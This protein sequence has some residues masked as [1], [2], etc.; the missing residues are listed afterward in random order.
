MPNVTYN[1]PPDRAWY[2]PL[3][4]LDN[5]WSQA[6]VN[7]GLGVGTPKLKAEDS[8]LNQVI[9]PVASAVAS[10]L[11]GMSGARAVRGLVG[12]KPREAL[13]VL[14]ASDELGFTKADQNTSG[15]EIGQ[16]IGLISPDD[17]LGTV[18]GMALDAV[19]NPKAI[20]GMGRVGVS[21]ARTLAKPPSPRVGIAAQTPDPSALGLGLGDAIIKASE[22]GAKTP[23]L[24]FTGD[25]RLGFSQ[26]SR[27]AR[28]I[29]KDVV[30]KAEDA[31]DSGT[32]PP[33]VDGLDMRLG[34]FRRQFPVYKERPGSTYSDPNFNKVGKLA[35]PSDSRY[36]VDKIDEY[37]QPGAGVLGYYDANSPHATIYQK[38][39]TREYPIHNRAIKGHVGQTIPYDDTVRH[40]VTHGLMDRA[41]RTG[42]IGELPAVMR[43]A[44]T[45]QQS[46][47]PFVRGI[48]QFLNEATA[49]SLGARDPATQ[50]R[51]AAGF[52]FNPGFAGRSLY[53]RDVGNI[54]LPAQWVINQLPYTV[55]PSTYAPAGGTALLAAIRNGGEVPAN[56]EF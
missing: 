47:S 30:T 16:N 43:V 50:M 18:K 27:M 53:A 8:A 46:G 7:G 38:A 36:Q 48:G 20:A 34:G 19:L 55:K 39:S 44:P 12:G 54:S 17:K 40:E 33:P 28:S 14:P 10:N 5:G 49:Q 25:Q 15:K 23:G 51:Y 45:M 52:L 9:A 56:G 11:D 21:L 2:N 29:I 42:R 37:H 26:N 22:R 6:P 4:Y 31:I 24:G 35:K 1:R 41:M 13:S 32:A 3:R